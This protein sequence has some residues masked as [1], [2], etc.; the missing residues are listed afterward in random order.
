MF[1]WMGEILYRTRLS[2]DMFEGLAPWLSRLPG[3]LLEFAPVVL[4]RRARPFSMHR[5]ADEGGFPSGSE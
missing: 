2:Q 1:I 3:R 4:P 5:L